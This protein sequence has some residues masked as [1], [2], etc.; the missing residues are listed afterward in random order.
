MDAEKRRTIES[1]AYPSLFVAL[2][3]LL[4][5]TEYFFNV[6]YVSYGIMPRQLKGLPG[7]AISPLIHGNFHHLISNTLPLLILG[8]I[9]CYF[10]RKIAFEVFF[11]VYL[12]TGVW[13]WFAAGG[14][15]YHI[16]ASGLIYGFASFLLFSGVFRKD[17][18][19][20]ALSLL[21]VFIYG[22]LVW[23]LLPLQKGVSWESH[24]FGS[25]SG[26]FC[27]FYYRKIDVSGNEKKA[28]ETTTEDTTPLQS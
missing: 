5:L 13:V 10:Y 2:L 1:L 6:S 28:E 11:W 18:R 26:G 22:G 8:I 15:G 24:L 21:V 12:L 16:G 3:W 17:M 20:I 4:R 25:M 9:I 19:S 23:G 7:I 27:A 14:N